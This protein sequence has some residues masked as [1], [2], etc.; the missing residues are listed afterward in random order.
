MFNRRPKNE[1]WE[2]IQRR[3][4]REDLIAVV[5]GTPLAY[6]WVVLMCAL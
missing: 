2:T 5:V 3:Q 1:K 6:V 4:R